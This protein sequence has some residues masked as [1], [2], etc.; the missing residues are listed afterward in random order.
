[1]L[2]IDRAVSRM[3]AAGMSAYV[4][5]KFRRSCTLPY[6]AALLN[7]HPLL[8]LGHGLSW[9]STPEGFDYWAEQHTALHYKMCSRL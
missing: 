5:N 1:M 3:Q 7:K 9:Y 2:A 8:L 6:D 4:T